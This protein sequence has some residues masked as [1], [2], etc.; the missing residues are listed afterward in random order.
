MIE[1]R[2]NPRVSIRCGVFFEYADTRSKEI[3]QDVGIALDISEKGMLLESG[4]PIQAATIKVM[5]PANKTKTVEIMGNVIYSIPMPNE[6]Y[7][8]GIVFHESGDDTAGLVKLLSRKPN[9]S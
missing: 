8:T 3:S 1:R 2:K 6:R 4:T 7:R 9:I 5:V